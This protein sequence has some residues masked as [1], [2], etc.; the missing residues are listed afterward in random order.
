MQFERDSW[1]ALIENPKVQGVLWDNPGENV[2]DSVY[3][4]WGRNPELVL[5]TVGDLMPIEAPTDNWQLV[6]ATTGDRF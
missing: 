5:E 3:V 6:G 4:Q 2:R 1:V